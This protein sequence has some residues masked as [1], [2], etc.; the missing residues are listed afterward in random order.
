MSHGKPV[1]L[2]KYG[3]KATD[4]VLLFDLDETL[5]HCFDPDSGSSMEDYNDTH[6]V[7]IKVMGEEIK[8]L[9][10]VRPFV[11]ECLVQVA[12]RFK[13]GIFTS[14]NQEYADAIID[15]IIDPSGSLI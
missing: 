1:S 8:A 6:Q 2:S 7:T 14:S 3:I 13:L 10:N 9:V 11:R 4:N 15:Q 5:V 12:S